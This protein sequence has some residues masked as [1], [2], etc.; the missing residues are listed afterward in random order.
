MSGFNFMRESYPDDWNKA[1]YGGNGYSD[2]VCRP[3]IIDAEGRKRPIIAY[4]PYQ[5]SENYVTERRERIVEHVR[6]PVVF[7]EY[8]YTS[9]AQVEPLRDY[10]TNEKWPP[11]Q[12]YDRPEYRYDS[13]PNVEPVKDS[14]VDNWRRPSSP[15]LNHPPK[16]KWPSSQ[17][18]DRPE[19][20]Y[21][22]PPKVEPVKDS[23]VDNWRRPSSP[24]HDRPPK[25]EDFIT[26]VQT[27]ASR[28]TRPLFSAVNWR[29]PPNAA[30]QGRVTDDRESDNNYKRDETF[31]V[32]YVNNKELGR[33]GHR[34]TTPSLQTNTPLSGPTNDI[35]KAMEVLT[36]AVKPLYVTSG[37]PQQRYT[38][39][40]STIPKRETYTENI[41][42]KEPARRYG[43]FNLSNR[44][45]QTND[46]YTGTID[47]R[48]AER[49]YNGAMV[50]LQ[51]NETYTGTIDS[52]E[53][54]RKYNGARVPLQTNETYTGIINSRDAARKYNGASV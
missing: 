6:A 28:P 37:A 53:A 47:S 43:N 34:V 49:K 20:R 15:V 30:G 7:T 13:P 52:R 45:L 48:E 1:N 44:P 8:K 23:R 42:S 17:V 5:S 14:R 46:N 40:T 4:P 18:Y 31:Q 41:D 11:S 3:V 19:Y 16:D 35:G 36:Q 27:E 22:S 32:P 26:K 38:V 51:T 33:P 9:Q 10:V 2:H 50:P 25:V 54:E 29:N 12:V 24:V 39:P 21:D